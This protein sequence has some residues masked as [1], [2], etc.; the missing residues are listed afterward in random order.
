[1]KY[2]SFLIKSYILHLTKLPL[3][4]KILDE[5]LVVFNKILH[6]TSNKTAAYGKNIR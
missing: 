1:M 5:V 4:A 2:L 3:T 6:I